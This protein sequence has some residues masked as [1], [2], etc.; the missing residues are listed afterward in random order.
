MRVAAKR[1]TRPGAS[2]STYTDASGVTS[3]FS[4]SYQTCAIERPTRVTRSFCVTAGDP[5]ATGD[6]VR[7]DRDVYLSEVHPS[8]ALGTA[9]ECGAQQLK[10]PL[11]ESSLTS[12]V[13]VAE[14]RDSHPQHFPL[15][16]V[17]GAGHVEAWN[18]D[19]QGH[20]RRLTDSLNSS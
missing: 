3:R 1:Q 9:V 14:R 6:K 8:D 20:Q 13:W 4:G 19:P 15:V 7:V 18:T 11:V 2:V 10:R 16:K 17:N 12:L 5:P